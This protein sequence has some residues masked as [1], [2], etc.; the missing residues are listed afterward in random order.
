MNGHT[1]LDIALERHDQ[2][3]D[4]SIELRALDFIRHIFPKEPTIFNKGTEFPIGIANY[5]RDFFVN[6]QALI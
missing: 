4:M 2:Y 6:N 5:T 3:K 1:V